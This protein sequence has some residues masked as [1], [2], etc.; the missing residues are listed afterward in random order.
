MHGHMCVC[1]DINTH[2]THVYICIYEQMYVC[3]HVCIYVYA[4]MPHQCIHLG[5]FTDRDT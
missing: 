5:I 2:Y 4:Y 3:M 1:E